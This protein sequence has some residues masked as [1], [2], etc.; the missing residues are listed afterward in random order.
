VI[1]QGLR[2]TLRLLHEQHRGGDDNPAR[3]AVANPSDENLR[4]LTAL[5][6]RELQ[7]GPVGG[8]E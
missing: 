1:T 6:E 8:V 4:R 5:K 7:D 3:Q 2:E